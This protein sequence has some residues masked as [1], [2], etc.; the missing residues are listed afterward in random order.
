M[1]KH[2]Q[3]NPFIRLTL[4]SPNIDYNT[5]FEFTA[6]V[7]PLSY[8][9][10][11]CLSLGVHGLVPYVYAVSTRNIDPPSVLGDL[12]LSLRMIALL[13][14]IYWQQDLVNQSL[15]LCQTKDRT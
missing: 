12:R 5:A 10:H 14:S 4:C 3:P 15:C 7:K 6:S 8:T 11:T 2:Q 1:D 9:Y 13:T